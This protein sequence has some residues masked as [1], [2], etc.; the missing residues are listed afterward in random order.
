MIGFGD[1]E[2]N[3]ITFGD[4]VIHEIWF[5][6]TQVW[7][8]GNITYTVTD[9]RLVY[10]SGVMI[11]AS[12]S[13]YAQILAT[14]R[15]Y[16]NN[17]LINEQTNYALPVEAVSASSS[18]WT[19]SGNIIT[20]VNRGTV[21]GSSRSAT[22]KGT[23][24][25]I[26]TS[27]FTVTQGSNYSNI[28]SEFDS[29]TIVENIDDEAVPIDT[30]YVPHAGKNNID[31][32][33]LQ[34]NYLD[35]SVYTSG[36]TLPAGSSSEFNPDEPAIP[37]T[38]EIPSGVSWLTVDQY[39]NLS[40]S[41]NTS[42]TTARDSSLTAVYTENDKTARATINVHQYDA[43]IRYADE[44][45]IRETSIG[46][47]GETTD[48]DEFD[49][50]DDEGIFLVISLSG[51]YQRVK[52]ENGH[53]QV[54]STTL[55]NRNDPSVYVELSGG[56]TNHFQFYDTDDQDPI[57]GDIAEFNF[58]GAEGSVLITPLSTNTGPDDITATLTVHFFDASTNLT[59]VHSGR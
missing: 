27:T 3:E 50:S 31:D 2:V 29:I 55:W 10:S 25:N 11:F 17:V 22:F 33:Y 37:D 41:A 18:I 34:L 15:T 19:V 42:T 26:D 16:R 28:H 51:M 40:A 5:G 1:I 39:G 23:W 21:E 49:P 48:H 6:D 47:D 8:V 30:Y 36:A 12:G 13:N 24:N 45:V 54:I 44:Y 14:V 56:D 35:T 7:P 4:S 58:S 9:A 57:P 38:Y 46:P 53:R 59:V 52:Y 32:I 20:A 43:S